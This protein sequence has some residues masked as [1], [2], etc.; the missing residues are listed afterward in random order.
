LQVANEAT[1][2]GAVGTV[3]GQATLPGKAGDADQGAAAQRSGAGAAN[4]W[5][6]SLFNPTSA[7]FAPCASA[8]AANAL[9]RPPH[10]P[11]ITMLSKEKVM[12]S[13]V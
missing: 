5:S 4:A 9:P 7:T 10:A 1:L 8:W 2:A 11:V 13:F 12:D 3:A 6:A